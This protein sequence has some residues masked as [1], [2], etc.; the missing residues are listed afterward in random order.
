MQMQFDSSTIYVAFLAYSILQGLGKLIRN[1]LITFTFADKENR[2]C[3]SHTR[4]RKKKSNPKSLYGDDFQ[5]FAGLP[6]GSPI[7]PHNTNPVVSP[8]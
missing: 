8:W 6:L 5:E 1:R 4:R 7:S 2:T 3:M